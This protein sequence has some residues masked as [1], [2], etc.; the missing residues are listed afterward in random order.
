MMRR[1]M[2][3]EELFGGIQTILKDKGKPP[4]TFGYGRVIKFTVQK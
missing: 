3:T 1:A 4:D 2:A